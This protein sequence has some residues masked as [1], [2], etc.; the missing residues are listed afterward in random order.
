MP[1]LTRRRLLAGAASAGL[2]LAGGGL[3]G[4]CQRPT[5]L[6]TAPRQRVAHL[7]FLAL[8]SAQDY[9]PYTAA[10]RAGLRDLGYTVGNNLV[11]DE[12]FAE[13]HEELLAGLADE[14]VE[15]DV[16]VLVTASTQA[17]LAALR[18]TTSIP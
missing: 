16:D 9:T 11:I 4:S 18:A 10:F 15:R 7:G 5:F 3:P 8:T 1:P 13:G 6:T 12:R 14:L 2:V 17:S